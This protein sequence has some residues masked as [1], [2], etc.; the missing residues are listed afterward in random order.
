MCDSRQVV[1]MTTIYCPYM[2]K[3][4]AKLRRKETGTD[5]V[6]FVGKREGWTINVL[7]SDCPE[8]SYNHKKDSLI[9]T[10]SESSSQPAPAPITN[11]DCEYDGHNNGR[12]TPIHKECVDLPSDIIS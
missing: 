9:T 12:C 7:A 11:I 2:K 3:F 1:N 4:Y 8:I 10:W 5:R 6:K